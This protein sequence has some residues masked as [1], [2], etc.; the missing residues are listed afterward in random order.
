MNEEI[1]CRDQKSH[2][3]KSFLL[4]MPYYQVV[5]SLWGSTWGMRVSSCS[6]AMAF[7]AS[8]VSFHMGIWSLQLIAWGRHRETG[9]HK[10]EQKLYIWP[11]AYQTVHVHAWIALRADAPG[12]WTTGEHINKCSN[13][14]I[15]VPLCTHSLQAKSLRLWNVFAA[16]IVVKTALEWLQKNVEQARAFE[17]LSPQASWWGNIVVKHRASEVTLLSTG[18][19]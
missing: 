13:N 10:W 11:C 17:S 6:R 15:L 18:E 7:L 5:Q 19:E 1:S 16:C 14:A 4:S 8:P 9:S 3:T 12:P 2:L